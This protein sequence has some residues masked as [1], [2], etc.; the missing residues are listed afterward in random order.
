M[1]HDST[2]DEVPISTLFQIYATLM[3]RE[4]VI[5]DYWHKN[6]GVTAQRLWTFTQNATVK[7]TMIHEWTLYVDR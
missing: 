1:L 3:A 5:P 2:D 4:P 6:Y 7:Q